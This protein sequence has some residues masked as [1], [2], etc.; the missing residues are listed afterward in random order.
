M[1][2][3]GDLAGLKSHL[4]NHPQLPLNLANVDHLSLLAVV[5]LGT[6]KDEERGEMVRELL[7]RVE[8]KFVDL[9]KEKMDKDENDPN[10]KKIDNYKLFA[11]HGQESGS[12]DDEDDEDDF[13]SDE[14]DDEDEDDDDAD[15]A[16]DIAEG[17]QTVSPGGMLA[18]SFAVSMELV[19]E[20]LGQ[21]GREE[22]KKH[23]E[24][25]DKL[26]REKAMLTK[27]PSYRINTTVRTNIVGLAVLKGNHKALEVSF[28]FFF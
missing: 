22:W 15:M 24:V 4:D 7:D 1:C 9:L 2:F 17:M 20:S 21:R 6:G 25:L 14:E 26:R 8:T 10:N 19:E 13:V 23:F 11:K 28:F 16:A 5:L 27:S 18:R 12:D 3:A